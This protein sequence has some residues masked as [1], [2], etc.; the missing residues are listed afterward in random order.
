MGRR[1]LEVRHW[2]I[3]RTNPPFHPSSIDAPTTADLKAWDLPGMDERSGERLGHTDSPG[4]RG[5]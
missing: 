3:C 5:N 1:H 2:R 4:E